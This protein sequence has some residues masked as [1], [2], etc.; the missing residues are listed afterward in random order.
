MQKSQEWP[1]PKSRCPALK[2]N[3][4]ESQETF[5]QMSKK[6]W[7][8]HVHEAWSV[9]SD[10]QFHWPKVHVQAQ[11]NS[12]TDQRVHIVRWNI[13]PGAALLVL[14]RH[15]MHLNYMHPV[16]SED[17]IHWTRVFQVNTQFHGYW[18]CAPELGNCIKGRP[19]NVKTI[20]W[21]PEFLPTFLAECDFEQLYC[22][23]TVKLFVFLRVLYFA[24]F[25]SVLPS[26]DNFVHSSAGY[27]AW[28]SRPGNSEICLLPKVNRQT[29]VRPFYVRPDSAQRERTKWLI[30]SL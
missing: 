21:G 13:Q 27:A 5:C 26:Q 23:S 11:F 4:S 2:W 25:T 28:G 24:V 15:W 3:M 19:Y 10:D 16:T 1:K 30:S 22:D 12:G 29:K 17:T 14:W 9:T 18:A 20:E 8:R 7:N 6:A